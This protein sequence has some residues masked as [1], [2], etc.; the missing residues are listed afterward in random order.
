MVD[1]VESK[2]SP[3]AGGQFKPLPEPPGWK[4]WHQSGWVRIVEFSVPII[5]LGAVIWIFW[6]EREAAG[7]SETSANERWRL[8]VQHDTNLFVHAAIGTDQQ[9]FV[10]EVGVLS[11][12]QQ[13][14][15]AG[16]ERFLCDMWNRQ[17]TPDPAEEADRAGL[18]LPRLVPTQEAADRLQGH[19]EARKLCGSDGGGFRE[20]VV[21]QGDPDE[22]AKR[23]CIDAPWLDVEATARDQ[24][25]FNGRPAAR[26]S[27]NIEAR[28]GHFLGPVEVLSETYRKPVKDLKNVLEQFEETEQSK[29]FTVD[30]T[31]GATRAFPVGY[32]ATI[33]CTNNRGTGRTC[34]AYARV[35]VKEFPESCARFFPEGFGLKPG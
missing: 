26:A 1:D 18:R 12:Q 27:L 11:E 20:L 5:A 22:T 31:T 23:E 33:A 9:E 35:R 16:R 28:S 14:Y 6:E 19:I 17:A 25:G 29:D 3:D 34:E 24:S 2:I 10:K 15:R 32:S 13:A 7:N 4:A 21:A 30:N 8:E